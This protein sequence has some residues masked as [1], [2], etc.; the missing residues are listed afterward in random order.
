MLFQNAR[1][2]LKDGVLE[3][4]SL[5]ME[6]GIIE[7]VGKNIPQNEC[8]EV[9]DCRGLYLSPGFIDIHS[10]GGGDHDIMDGDAEDI[11]LA[12][13]AHLQH[14][15]TTYYPT[16]MTSSDEDLFRTFD[17]FRRALECSEALPHMPGLHLEGPFLNPLEKGAQSDEYIKLPLPENYLPLLEKGDG[18]IARV[19]FAPELE[20]ALSLAQEL[21]RR[22]IMAAAGHTAA[23]YEEIE[24][25][26]DEGVRHL[27]HFYSGMSTITRRGGFRI[28]GAV[29]AGYLLDGMSIELI[30]DGIHLPPELLRMILKLKDHDHIC[31]ITDSMRGAGMGEGPS[32]LGA[33]D[34]GTKVI[35]EDGIAKLPDRSCFAG[36]ICTMD[37]AVRTMR[38]KAG[39]SLAEAIRMASFNPAR[40]MGIDSRTGSLEAGKAADLLIF[41]E[42]IGIKEVYVSGRRAFRERA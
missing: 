13:R 29:E 38:D 14:G 42:D 30:S 19:S 18:I 32:I 7:R 3:D 36:S 5:R 40:F 27:T 10:H 6:A 31:L 24:R 1:L 25:A 4:G 15:T 22:G 12:A 8:E 16:T 11:I 41:D 9:V 23:T 21:S 39:L 2:I 35:I 26:Y 28:L 33:R 34:T 17:C 20:G 37:R